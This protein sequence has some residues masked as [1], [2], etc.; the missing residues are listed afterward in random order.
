MSFWFA[1][2]LARGALC[3]RFGFFFL[4]FSRLSNRVGVFTESIRFF[5]ASSGGHSGAARCS[6]AVQALRD[7][8]VQFS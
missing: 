8:T 3:H 2:G 1:S 5:N 6:I 7:S 4:L